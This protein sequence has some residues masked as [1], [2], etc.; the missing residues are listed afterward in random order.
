MIKIYP[1]VIVLSLTLFSVHVSADKKTSIAKPAI[2][3]TVS[4]K[5]TIPIVTNFVG[6]SKK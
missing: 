1:F 5:S 4:F 3:N 6:K 2:S